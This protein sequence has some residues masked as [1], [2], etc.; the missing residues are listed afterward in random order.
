MVRDFPKQDLHLHFES[1]DIRVRPTNFHARAW[2]NDD[3]FR[4][5]S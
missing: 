2:K 4:Q 3:W 1:Y 5:C